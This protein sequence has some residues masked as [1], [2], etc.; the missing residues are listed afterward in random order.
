[1]RFPGWYLT[2]IIC[3]INF[4]NSVQ[5]TNED[6]VGLIHWN[7]N[8]IILTKFSSIGALNIVKITNSNASSDENV[9]KITTISYQCTTFGFL[10]MLETGP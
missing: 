4:L 10:F 5:N 2:L 3:E 8:V 7:E 1:M 6:K 9:I